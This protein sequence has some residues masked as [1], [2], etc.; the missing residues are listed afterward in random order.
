M[1]SR[2]PSTI[3][4]HCNETD[5]T[6]TDA[7]RSWRCYGRLVYSVSSHHCSHAMIWHWNGHAGSQKVK[8]HD[9]MRHCLISVKV[10]GIFKAFQMMLACHCFITEHWLAW[11]VMTE[12]GYC[13]FNDMFMIE[14]P[15]EVIQSIS[16][17]LQG[18]CE[19][20]SF[21]YFKLWL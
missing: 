10:L 3:S 19:H 16:L 13:M 15:S 17:F 21:E 5:V 18:N 1:R 11:G 4:T 8:C 7:S 6:R 2:I 9:S 20:S 12:S 14:G